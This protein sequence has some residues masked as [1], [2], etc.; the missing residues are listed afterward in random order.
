MKNEPTQYTRHHRCCRKNGGTDDYPPD[1]VVMLPRHI[2]E[3]WHTIFGS[4]TPEQIAEYMNEWFIQSDYT[5]I[6][7]HKGKKKTIKKL[8]P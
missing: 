7:I 1:N 3:A 5:M 2:H 8:E 4:R 6:A